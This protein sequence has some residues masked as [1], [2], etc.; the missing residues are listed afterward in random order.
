MM[1]SP[2]NWKK[3][4]VISYVRFK[5]CSDGMKA[6]AKVNIFFDVCRLFFDLFAG[7]LIFFP[8]HLVWVGPY[9]TCCPKQTILPSSRVIIEFL[10]F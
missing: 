2:L 3:S 6:N 7:S 4:H 5:L 10:N 8:F 1:P 9:N